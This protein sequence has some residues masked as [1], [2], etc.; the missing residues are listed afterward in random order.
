MDYLLVALVQGA[1]SAPPHSASVALNVSTWKGLSPMPMWCYSECKHTT[2]LQTCERHKGPGGQLM[3]SFQTP[4]LTAFSSKCTACHKSC[5]L[6]GS[7][8]ASCSQ[9]R[10]AK[11]SV[12]TLRLHPGLSAPLFISWQHKDLRILPLYRVTLLQCNH[13]FFTDNCST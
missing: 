3:P 11:L 12:T 13:W 2:E 10:G 4:A 9:S 8:P 1:H 6:H 5:V 7:L